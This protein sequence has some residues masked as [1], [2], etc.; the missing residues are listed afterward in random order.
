MSPLTNWRTSGSDRSP[1]LG[2][3]SAGDEPAAVQQHHAV[4][5]AKGAIHLVRHHHAGHAQLACSSS[6]IRWS[7]SA[8]VTG[9]R[10][11]EGSS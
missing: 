6:M 8:L 11:A 10:P 7:I 5:D 9:S 3:G 4:G 2:G 1:H